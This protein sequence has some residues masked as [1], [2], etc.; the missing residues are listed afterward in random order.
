MA[1]ADKVLSINLNNDLNNKNLLL[2]YLKDDKLSNLALDY[3][4]TINQKYP[5]LELTVRWN[6]PAF[7]F[8]DRTIAFL[9]IKTELEKTK[10]LKPHL[11]LGFVS[12]Y[13]LFADKIFEDTSHTNVRYV[14]ITKLSNTKIAKIIDILG[15]SM[16]L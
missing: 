15:Q 6:L 4:N 7:V 12:G 9:I 1:C 5:Y 8:G 13:K 10:F 3:C 14:D 2:R 16:E 11:F